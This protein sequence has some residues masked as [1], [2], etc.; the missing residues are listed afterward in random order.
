IA[1]GSLFG[2][3]MTLIG[4]PPN[5]I[6]AAYRADA[7]GSPYRMFDFT[8]VGAAITIVG[9]LACGLGL[10]RLLPRREPAASHD[11]LFDIEQ[12][13][14]ELRIKEDSKAASASVRELGEAA[15]G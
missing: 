7:V 14:A 5:I 4:T 9:V 8:P 2:G 1:F 13:T 12:Y 6:I 10:W 15:E 11:L 3:M